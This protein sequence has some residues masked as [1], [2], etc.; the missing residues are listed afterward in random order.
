M[1]IKESILKFLKLD[2]LL[3]NLSGYIETRVQLLKLE[4]REEIAKVISHGLIIGVCFL[5]ALLFVIFVSIGLANY[6][7]VIFGKPYIGYLM[8]SGFYALLFIVIILL[9][10]NIAQYIERNLK[11]QINKA[12]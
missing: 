4:V 5:F 12:K 1:D 7:N 9:R 3:S 2:G 6:I 8:V 10:K 11:E